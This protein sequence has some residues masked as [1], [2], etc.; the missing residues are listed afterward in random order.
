MAV[1]LRELCVWVLVVAAVGS[2]QKLLSDFK[3]C[4]DEECSMLMCRGKALR[5]F[6]GPDCR[7]LKFKAGETIYVYYK[8][9]GK[10]NDIWAGS[11]GSQF[12][13]F[14]K[15]LIE[16]NLVY[17]TTEVELPS[18]DTDFVCFNEGPDDFDDVE[19]GELVGAL[20]E[21]HVVLGGAAQLVP[22]DES[23]KTLG[24][25]GNKARAEEAGERE[26]KVQPAEQGAGSP[27]TW[28]EGR[29]A[30]SPASSKESFH[31]EEPVESAVEEGG[32]ISSLEDRSTEGG[33]SSH[34]KV[35]TQL[36]SNP[37]EPETLSPKEA[38]SK[39]LSQGSSVIWGSLVITELGSQ[40]G[41]QS[42]LELEDSSQLETGFGSTQD[43]IVVDD[44]VTHNIAVL[45]KDLEFEVELK[46]EDVE[47][48]KRTPLIS[49]SGNGSI[50]EQDLVQDNATA[51]DYHSEPSEANAKTTPGAIDT[52]EVPKKGW[53]L[54]GEIEDTAKSEETPMSESGGLQTTLGETFSADINGNKTMSQVTNLDGPDSEG[55]AK[56]VR[57]GR[58]EHSV[59]EGEGSPSIAV[60][61]GVGVKESSWLGTEGSE[62]TVPA[63]AP[64][65][66]AETHRETVAGNEGNE[67]EQLIRS[68]VESHVSGQEG[69]SQTK[70]STFNKEVT[71]GFVAT[72]E[73]DENHQEVVQRSDAEPAVEPNRDPPQLVRMEPGTGSSAFA[74]TEGIDVTEGSK[75]EAGTRDGFPTG[76]VNT[77]LPE[78]TVE[79]EGQTNSVQGGPDPG[80]HKAAKG[81]D[82][83]GRNDQGDVDEPPE[84]Y[85]KLAGDSV[86]EEGPGEADDESLDEPEELLEDEN[87]ADA[88]AARDDE[89]SASQEGRSD[90]QELDVDDVN[91]TEE[92]NNVETEDLQDAMGGL[93]FSAAEKDREVEMENIR[94][95]TNWIESQK[96]SHSPSLR[97]VD[98]HDLRAEREGGPQT[99]KHFLGVQHKERSEFAQEGEARGSGADSMRGNASNPSEDSANK[100][101]D[102]RLPSN[103][104]GAD[105]ASRRFANLKHQE[106]VEKLTIL[107]G[108]LAA[109]S[110]ALVRKYLS[111]Q[112]VLE[113]EANLHSME[114]KLKLA[115]ST[116]SD[117]QSMESVLDNILEDWETR[118]LEMVE[119]MLDDRAEENQENN[120]ETML[121]NDLQELVYQ[122]RMKYSD[123]EESVAFDSGEQLSEER[124][125]P[126]VESL[127]QG[128]PDEADKEV[129]EDSQL[130]GRRPLPHLAKDQ[131]WSEGRQELGRG[132][133]SRGTRGSM[134][135]TASQEWEEDEEIMVG[136]PSAETLK[137]VWMEHP[138][139]SGVQ[140]VAEV[141]PYS[142]Q[143]QPRGQL[144]EKEGGAEAPTSNVAGRMEL[145]S[146]DP[147]PEETVA[148]DEAER[149]NSEERPAGRGSLAA[150]GGAE[151]GWEEKQVLIHGTD[152]VGLSP[153]REEGTDRVGLT[154]LREV[155]ARVG[156]TSLREG[157]DRVGHT[158]LR[159]GTGRAGH[160]PLREGT[161]RT[162]H[163]PL[164]EG[165]D[166]IGHTA[167]REGT[168]RAGHTPLKEGTDH[169]GHTPLREET[170]RAGHTPL[171][172]GT[173][174]AGHTP[175]REGTDRAGHTPLREG[176][177]REGHTPLREETDRA[178]HTPLREG[179]DRV[180]HTPLR[181]MNRVGHTPLREEEMDRADKAKGVADR[182]P[183]E[184]ERG[185]PSSHE[186]SQWLPGIILGLERAVLASSNILRPVARLLSQALVSSLPEEMQPGPAFHGL[187]WEPILIT[188]A[189]G[190]LSSFIFMWR[191]CL[192]VKSR[193]YQ[194]TE[195]QLAE[196][197]KQLIQEK[198][199]A[200]E[201][202]SS[203]EKK[204]EE[205]KALINEAQNVKST[206]S[207]DIKELEESCRELEQVN[208]HLENRVKSLQA[209]LEK[210][211]AET[212]KQQTVIADSQ[213]SVAKLQKVISAHTA[214]LSQVQEVLRVAKANEE[215]MQVD[216]QSVLEENARLTQSKSQL[217]LE[218]EGWS[219][220]HSELTE[221][222]KF[223]QKAQRD[224]EETLAYKD[225]EIE[226]LTDCVMQLRQLDAE[227]DGENN[228][229][230]KEVDGE[231]A[232]GELPDK[233]KR[234]K[235]QKMM[236]VSRVKTT[237]KI[238]EEEKD[239][240]QSK[241]IDEIKAR[242]EL[243]E[244]IKQL[245]HNFAA[246]T[247]EKS[248]LE[249]EFKTMQQKL[250][251][252]TELY[253]QKEMAL[254]KKLTQEECQRQEKELKLSV[255]DEKA[256]QALE[257]VKMYKQRIQ[258]MEEEL[259]KT[260][261]SFKNQIAAHEKKAHENWLSARSAERTLT[262]E[263]RETANLRQK[264]IELNQKLSQV[265]R[266]SIIKPMPGRPDRQVPPGAPPP[267][268]PAR[269]APVSRDDSYG[270]S[271]VSMGPPSPPMIMEHLVR[272]P[273]VNAGRGFPRDR[274][275]GGHRVPPSALPSREWVG[276]GPDRMGPSSDH[277]SPPLQWDWRPGPM[278]GYPAPWRPP[279]E[280]GMMSGRISGPGEIRGLPPPNR[281]E[282]GS[283]GPGQL[284][285]G[286]RTSSPI[287]TECAAVNV[288]ASL[289]TPSFPGAPIMN[290]PM[291]GMPPPGPR[292]GLPPPRGTYGPGP[293]PQNHPVRVPALRDYPPAPFPAPGH[294]PF[295]PGPLLPP[296]PLRDFP[297]GAR[298][299]PRGPRS[300]PP[301]PTPLSGAHELP[302]GPDNRQ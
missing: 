48:L 142:P 35:S 188:A 194:I 98:A 227:S 233:N 24:M 119:S 258:E 121:V 175:L 103:E 137:E 126:Q 90:E 242:H 208:L 259:L 3:R 124:D 223:C 282:M 219:E 198:V 300:L 125:Y 226:V 196:K 118:I 42:L 114:T 101:E 286:P 133:V 263:K 65:S 248:R 25:A 255:A 76:Y 14:P 120:E 85:S 222:I 260:E 58:S 217:L 293:L 231:V 110:L 22:S 68:K 174:R 72:A 220:R 224:L 140:L 143:A 251:I 138:A 131:S 54:D 205:T 182:S 80:D 53:S 278:D 102:I 243:E 214:E 109:T 89:A 28:A 186:R 250:E 62:A 290:S 36:E 40:E 99:P 113:I 116:R 9:A 207:V 271:P 104:N 92:S 201:N 107:K 230:D 191:T 16:I 45:D 269:R 261:R 264:M 199:E 82:Q 32:D 19:I 144:K 108:S 57:D 252:L 44:E 177:D 156:H 71:D 111:P 268:G 79:A 245:E 129:K 180:G 33:D 187:P 61:T 298:E 123:S 81:G 64:S 128:E 237:L 235:I 299:Y 134:E 95:Q 301:E 157:T 46:K 5:D 39:G 284:P 106:A 225:N 195:K 55:L 164:R 12:G 100:T 10:R 302:P 94:G 167:L 170:D 210:E 212:T 275:D 211:K 281:A 163:T 84:S 200:L 60:E 257:E 292:H 216:L 152:S 229:W 159:E 23:E 75:S 8:L 162:G 47:L 38:G 83:L 127:D 277:G 176:T 51:E 183:L 291:A 274:G 249:N 153:M 270:P 147:S 273:S 173:D 37:Q 236:D 253:H 154:L 52:L 6:V 161:D 88:R 232:N 295:L 172:E 296:H 266:P 87:A 34:V 241:L 165:T 69:K 267:L 73:R 56:D 96:E 288:S 74:S 244:Q 272:P 49:Y 185:S 239:H 7:F 228:G 2:G 27:L 197:I 93:N 17:S 139:L 168:G 59:E 11:V 77:M 206:A 135:A 97:S 21:E 280:T 149:R 246:T 283:G 86:S 221:Q 166:R 155:A 218:A 145:A 184:A 117:E 254:Q 132:E 289:S 78:G 240:F 63:L 204:L 146:R 193:R 105:N 136:V 91:I 31:I 238:I 148:L 158:A 215:K 18:E 297:P 285:S 202:V 189:L 15:D 203:Y 13:Y 67:K 26:E 112:Q 294:R 256:L 234:M 141:E 171:R 29:E 276:P 287:V 122:L 41:E 70:S 262:V 1:V 181:E 43:A 160:T 209:S 150:G 179:T 20:S 4:Q 178:G 151:E 190:F 115:M 213:K 130:P 247:T 279:S 66:E 265:Q 50:P 169:A 192:S 30:E